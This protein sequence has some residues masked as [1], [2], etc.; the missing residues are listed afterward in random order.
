MSGLYNTKARFGSVGRSA[1]M[2]PELRADATTRS[3]VWSVGPSFGITVHTRS[4]SGELI[5][6]QTIVVK[7]TGKTVDEAVL[8]APAMVAATIGPGSI[9]SGN[10]APGTRG[11]TGRDAPRRELIRRRSTRLNAA[12][13]AAEGS[14]KPS[15]SDEKADEAKEGEARGRAIQPIAICGWRCSRMCWTG[16]CRSR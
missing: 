9:E 2:Q 4:C 8:Q 5:S 3:T 11:K 6:G 7:T 1:P 15:Q 16:N 12:K 13:A 14:A 10:K